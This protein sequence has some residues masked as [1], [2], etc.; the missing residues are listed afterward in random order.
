MIQY[1]RNILWL[2]EQKSIVTKHTE[3]CLCS[4]AVAMCSI[5]FKKFSLWNYYHGLIVHAD[6]WITPNVIPVYLH[7]ILLDVWDIYCIRKILVIIVPWINFIVTVLPV[8]KAFITCIW[9]L[10][11]KWRRRNSE[12]LRGMVGFT[13]FWRLETINRL[14]LP[15]ALVI[16][17]R[18][19]MEQTIWPQNSY[20]ESK[21]PG[22][23][24]TMD[25]CI[26][27]NSPAIKVHNKGGDCGGLAI[28]NK[29]NLHIEAGL[30][31]H[32]C[33]NI[34]LVL[35]LKGSPLWD[36]YCVL[37]FTF[38]LKEIVGKIIIQAETNYLHYWKG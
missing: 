36:F 14:L 21:G 18:E 25:D 13:W 29:R 9:V 28:A 31:F 23:W 33:E 37:I 11:E 1:T 19:V 16:E 20:E 8:L 4:G 10:W 32:D 3:L 17:C 30:L 22:L 2:S 7:L 35:L 24:R 34:A 5:S 6:L 15:K 26:I 27:Y 12:W 38:H